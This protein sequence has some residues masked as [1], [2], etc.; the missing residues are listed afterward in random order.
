MDHAA[1]QAPTAPVPSPVDGGRAAP[2]NDRELDLPEWAFDSVESLVCAI[3][4]QLGLW[5]DEV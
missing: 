1:T 3:G 5:P 4:E 2:P